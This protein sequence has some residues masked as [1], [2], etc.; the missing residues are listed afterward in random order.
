VMEF[1]MEAKKK[2][3]KPILGVE[4]YVAPR[5]MDKKDGRADR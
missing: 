3:I 5:G 2:G 1:Y 4:A